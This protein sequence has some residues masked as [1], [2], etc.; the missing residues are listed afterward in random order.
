MRTLIYQC[1]AGISG[2]MNLGAMIQLGVDPKQ[3]EAELRKLPLDGWSL[4][5]EPD[6]RNG[7]TGIRCDVV[8]EGEDK[9]HDHHHHHHEHE[10]DHGHSHGHHHEHDHDDHHHSH[11]HHHHHR[12]FKDIREM[13][14]G[15]AMAEPIK[16]DAVACFLALA[17]AEAAVHGMTVDE[18]HFHEV[19]AVDSI[20]DMVGAAACWHLLGVEQVV[21]TS[22]EL[23]G[24]TVDC[25]HGRMPVPAPATARLVKGLPV[26]Q[27][28][29]NKEATTPTGAALLVGKG[30]AFGKAV[31]GTLVANGVGIGQRKDPKL[32]NVVYAALYDDATAASPSTG[33]D[34]DTVWELAA[35]IDDMTA[36]SLAYLC[37]RLLEAGA[38][39]A[40]QVPATFKKGRAGVIVHALAAE[41]ERQA[42]EQVFIQ[43]SQ[44]LGIRY[45][46]WQRSKLQR[47]L[48]SAETPWGP[49]QLKV[50][51]LNGR[52][53]R[54]KP[55]H[56]DCARIAREHNVPL[57]TVQAAAWQSYA[58]T[59]EQTS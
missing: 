16:R 37:E 49:V 58:E 18:V 21:C 42:I 32:A 27:G 56:E 47:D 46:Q 5:F 12:T 57:G 23:G 44:T 45:Q 54:L 31:K 28:A 1:P 53:V 14:E 22:L 39:D 50:A 29:T 26:S 59:L 41:T 30:A 55:E 20:V 19:G 33:L 51:K 25:Q 52:I 4:H 34:G 10:H 6:V 15:S 48:V 2:D 7:I 36:E 17:E 35:N 11:D 40:W 13:I 24:G 38:L 43:D 3:L 9:Q 8:L